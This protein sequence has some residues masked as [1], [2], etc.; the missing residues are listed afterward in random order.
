MA[1]DPAARPAARSRRRRRGRATSAAPIRARRGFG[2]AGDFAR[3]VFVKAD[4]DQIFFMAGAI[5]FNVLIAIVPLTLGALGVAGLI[6]QARYVGN[7]ADPVL[8]YL[9]S[10]MPPVS[11]RVRGAG[12]GNVLSGLIEQSTGVLSVSTLILIWVSTRLVGTLRTALR[13]IFDIQQDR[14]IVAGK[15]FDVKMVITAGTLLAINV[16]LTV[17]LDLLGHYGLDFLGLDPDAFTGFSRAY[18]TAGAFVSIWIMF[19]L[20][21]RYLPARRIQWRTAFT[22]ATFTSVLFELLKAG[23]TWYV[24]NADYTTAYGSLATLIL[25]FLWVYWVAIVFILGGEVAQVAALQRIRRR[26][27]ERLGVPPEGRAHPPAAPTAPTP[28]RLDSAA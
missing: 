28:S 6:L 16:F 9:V 21:Y 11:G 5:A 13:E 14:G 25:V 3:R 17:A 4:Q 7:P 8:A 15:I 27:K 1:S 12:A 18:T 26:Q 10:V 2:V 24:R 20:I 22:A 19:V 23:F